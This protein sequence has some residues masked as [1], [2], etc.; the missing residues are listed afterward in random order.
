[1]L[2]FDTPIPFNTAGKRHQS[3]VPTQA[4]IL[5]NDPFVVEQAKKWAERII[6]K[7]DDRD[8][9]IELMFQ[10]AFGRPTTPPEMESAKEFLLQQAKERN[11]VEDQMGNYSEIWA[12]LCHVIFNM[13]EFIYIK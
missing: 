2:A 11:V 7:P 5:M 8:Q 1:M 12:D 10:R 4:L 3:N 9:R 13:K 6:A